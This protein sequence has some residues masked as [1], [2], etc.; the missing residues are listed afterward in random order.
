MFFFILLVF[1]FLTAA[2]YVVAGVHGDCRG[3]YVTEFQLLITAVGLTFFLR[4]PLGG[5][6]RD[7]SSGSAS[8]E[9]PSGTRGTSNDKK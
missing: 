5:I 3:F 7:P 8:E 9:S 6:L 2:L 1:V 4:D